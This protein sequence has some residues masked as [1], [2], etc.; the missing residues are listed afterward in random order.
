MIGSDLTH[1][2][3]RT[4]EMLIGILG[5]FSREMLSVVS[6]VPVIALQWFFQTKSFACYK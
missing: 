4:S 1:N 3:V 2:L 5:V 6:N